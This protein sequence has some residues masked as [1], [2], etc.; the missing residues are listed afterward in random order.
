MLYLVH[1]SPNIEIAIVLIDNATDEQNLP[2][3][4]GGKSGDG[5]ES[6]STIYLPSNIF[7][8]N[9]RHGSQG[10]YKIMEIVILQCYEYWKTVFFYYLSVRAV[11]GLL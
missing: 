5:N 2:L 7:D 10:K 6:D 9:G 4:F 3:E 11:D 8:L 1:F